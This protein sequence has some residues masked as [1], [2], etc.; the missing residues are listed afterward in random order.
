V[1][2]VQAGFGQLTDRVGGEFD[3][4][5]CMGGSLSHVLSAQALEETLADF[6]AMLRP[7]GVLV[8]QQRNFGRVC[9]PR[10]RF[11]PLQTYQ[12]DDREWILFRFYDFGEELITF[13][14]VTLERKGGRWDYRVQA[15]ELRPIFQ[16]ELAG[17]L[18]RAG[19][20][21]VTCYGNLRGEPFDPET[22]GNLVAV[23]YRAQ[24]GEK[25]KGD[26]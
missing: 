8:I 10:Q 4:L 22:S 13:N 23:A 17:L 20:E 15:T 2:F 25:G 19:F 11:M 9:R 7:G 5:I 3:G 16:R 12:A 1:P 26:G 24:D 14:M 18:G 6:A 21:G